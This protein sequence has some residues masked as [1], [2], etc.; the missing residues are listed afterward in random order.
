M[1]S[2]TQCNNNTENKTSNNEEAFIKCTYIPL[3]TLRTPACRPIATF[4]TRNLGP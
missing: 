1:F 3:P 2:S 4:I